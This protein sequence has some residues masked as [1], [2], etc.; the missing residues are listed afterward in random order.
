MELLALGSCLP[1]PTSTQVSFALGM[2]QQGWTG[3]LLSGG[4]PPASDQA[5]ALCGG[6]RAGTAFQRRAIGCPIRPQ[7]GQR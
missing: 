7:S 3:G 5:I 4:D 1:G 6:M 2:M